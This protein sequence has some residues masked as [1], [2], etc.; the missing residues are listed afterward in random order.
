MFFSADLLTPVSAYLRIAKARDT[1]SFWESVEG[2]KKSRVI[3]LRAH[4]PRK[5]SVRQRRVR[6]ESRGRMVWEERDP[7]S[8]LR[9]RVDA[10]SPRAAS[11]MPPSG[12]RRHRF[13]QAMT[14]AADRAHSQAPPG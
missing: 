3:R 2:G 9:E 10:F 8:F 7:I 11:R 14:C 5:F 13:F 4:T 12:R 6:L 1:P